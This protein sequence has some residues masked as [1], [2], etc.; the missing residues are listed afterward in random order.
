MRKRSR[1]PAST[2]WWRSGLALTLLAAL[3][4]AFGEDAPSP[5]VP[6]EGPPATAALASD[7]PRAR[8]AAPDPL[9]ADQSLVELRIEGPLRALLRDN[10]PD[11]EEH[12]AVMSWR[13]ADGETGTLPIEYRARGKSR[14][15]PEKCDFPPIRLD[16]PRGQAEGTLFEEQDKL[17]LV[18][19]CTRLGGSAREQ[20]EWV[21][22]EYHAYRLLNGLTDYGF[23]ARPLSVTYVDE[24]GREYTH[25]AFLIESEERMAARL[26]LEE[27]DLPDVDHE[28]IA[29]RIGTV[30]SL[31]QY[32]IGNTDFSFLSGPGDETCCHN[33]IHV[34]DGEGRFV[35]IPY[36]FDQTGLLNKPD[37]QPARGLAIRKVTDRRFRGFCVAPEELEAALDLF[38]ERRPELERLLAEETFELPDARRRRAG[39]FLNQ[40][41]RVLDDPRRIEREFVDRCRA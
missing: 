9:F 25:P 28:A 20:R 1:G 11:P 21:W 33:A 5:D 16:I 39:R 27:N 36:D 23:R 4:A 30:M 13:T 10:S 19:H 34:T 32:M 8:S 17:K 18:T 6:A 15:R 41:W 31:F 24:N 7:D 29:P 38:R 2:P 12:D 37:A 40:F 14:R 26:G 3:P 22:L 35:P